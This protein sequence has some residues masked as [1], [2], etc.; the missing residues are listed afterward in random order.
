MSVGDKI[1]PKE[2]FVH[3]YMKRIYTVSQDSPL[4]VVEMPQ[5]DLK[6]SHFIPAPESE[7]EVK[8]EKSSKK[9]AK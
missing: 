6:P 2:E 3:L 8:T 4:Q 7:P 1:I 9:K 5:R